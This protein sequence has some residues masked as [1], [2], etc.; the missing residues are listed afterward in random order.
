MLDFFLLASTRYA[1]SLKKVAG[2]TLLNI[3]ICWRNWKVNVMS[4]YACMYA[5]VNIYVILYL[6]LNLSLNLYTSISSLLKKVSTWIA[7]IQRYGHN[8]ETSSPISVDP[9]W[10]KLPSTP[11]MGIRAP[12]LP[13]P[14][15]PDRWVGLQFMAPKPLPSASIFRWKDACRYLAGWW[16]K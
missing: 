6:Y 9:H 7:R 14:D 10:C 11:T 2:H 4:A 15:S 3:D 13:V 1:F 16:L 5:Y 12:T 8:W